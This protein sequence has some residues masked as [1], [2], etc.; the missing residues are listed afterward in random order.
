[1]RDEERNNN[2][3]GN[4]RIHIAEWEA[5]RPTPAGSKFTFVWIV[6]FIGAVVVTVSEFRPSL[7]AMSL[8]VVWFFMS[9][10]ICK[11]IIPRYNESWVEVFD[12]M[13]SE[14]EPLNL[15]AWEHLKRQTETEGLTVS[16]VRNWYQLEV[17][18]VWPEKKPDLKFLHNNPDK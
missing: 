15:P 5:G 1:M 16:N 14:Y 13:L 8:L 9:Q 2:L 17:M 3:L 7:L 12:R 11:R 4:M 10:M 6:A 18:S